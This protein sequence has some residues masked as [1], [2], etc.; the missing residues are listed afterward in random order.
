[1]AK[2]IL[3]VVNARDNIHVLLRRLGKIVKAGHRI[4]F[5]L[6]YQDDIPTWLLA[7]ITSVQTGSDNPLAWQQKRAWL[8]WDQQK[9]R[10]EKT[11]G[12]PAR[13]VFSQIG[14]QVEIDLYCPPLNCVMKR[15]L[16]NGE[17]A[18]ILVGRTSWIGWLKI[19]PISLRNWCVRRLSGPL[20]KKK[21]SETVLST[22]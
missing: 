13:K 8:S 1:M 16:K 5:L 3:V 17:I 15:Y 10:A 22:S 21:V 19:V 7:Q 12:E 9:E 4:V 20:S 6:E 14:V 2:T 11:L 18:L